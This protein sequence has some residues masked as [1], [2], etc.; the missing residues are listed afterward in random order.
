MLK[1][2]K[3]IS[4]DKYTYG[5]EIERSSKNFLIDMASE[6]EKGRALDIG[7]GTGVNA[8][9][10]KKLG[11]KI[12][13]LDLSHLAIKKLIDNGH[14]GIV[15]DIAKGIPFEENSF[16][17]VFASEV[18][19]HLD[20]IVDFL[21]EIKRVLKPGGTLLL[22]TPNSVFWAYRILTLIGKS[23]SEFQHPG[24]LRFFSPKLLL[25]HLQESAFQKIQMSGRNIYFIVGERFA[26]LFMPLLRKLPFFQYETRFLTKN[27]FFHISKKTNHVS[28][29][30]SDTI[31]VKA[32]K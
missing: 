8:N 4:D 6:C 31:L 21:T 24:H 16:E 1:S 18:I 19:E 23:P 22:S 29:I 9:H 14:E 26:K 25:S 30:W 27:K 10:L 11:F 17:L 15:H 5:I 2:E 3:K 28:A 12:T 13:G 32:K 7:C 20:D